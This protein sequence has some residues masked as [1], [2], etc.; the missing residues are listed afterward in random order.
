MQLN[1]DLLFLVPGRYRGNASAMNAGAAMEAPACWQAFT[2]SALNFG[3][4][5]QRVCRVEYLA[6]SDSLNMVRTIL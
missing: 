4:Y 1:L 3:V 6:I 5:V 2:N